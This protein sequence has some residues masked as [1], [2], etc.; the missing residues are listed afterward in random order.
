MKQSLLRTAK[1]IR[2]FELARRATAGHLRVLAYH[3]VWTTPGFQFGNHLFI[4]PEQFER[5]MLWVKKSRYAVL[6]LDEAINA[7][8]ADEL[9]HDCVVITIDDG[10]HSTYTC[11]L[12]VLESLGIPATVYVTTWY[13]DHRAPVA[14]VAL[15]YVLQRT[16]VPSIS[17]RG[18]NGL[19]LGNSSQREATADELRRRLQELPTLPDRLEALRE[20]C[21]LAEVPVEPWW[22]DGQFHLMTREELGDA[23]RRGFDVQLHTHRHT[24]VASNIAALASEISENRRVLA[25]ACGIDHFAHFCYP[26]GEYNP[27]AAGILMSAGIKSAMLCDVG[28]NAPGRDPYALHRFLDG[29][30]VSDVAFEAYMSGALDIFHM[31]KAKIAR[32][33]GA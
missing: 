12:P 25:E 8:S 15:N 11:M 1:I 28:L 26:G 20:I 7:L 13:V 33:L 30:S 21:R 22:S 17:W 23:Y 6:A 27:A 2:G 9:R 29:R 4:T 16:T 19:P 3:G 14:N 24:S 5:R 10:W 32:S 18:R 31:I